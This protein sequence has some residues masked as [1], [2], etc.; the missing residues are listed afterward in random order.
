MVLVMNIL[1]V[2]HAVKLDQQLDDHFTVVDMELLQ[3][4]H[5][6]KA[7]DARIADLSRRLA[8]FAGH[9]DERIVNV[10]I[11][12][13]KHLETRILNTGVDVKY[14]IKELINEIKNTVRTE[15]IGALPALEKKCAPKSW[16]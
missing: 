16:W 3:I 2:L 14:L 7:T 1:L 9:L 6:I 5:N 12:T 4:A 13:V 15:R 11:A 10:G 8:S